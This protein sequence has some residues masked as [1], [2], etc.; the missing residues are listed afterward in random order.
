MELR[1]EKGDLTPLNLGQWK[2]CL[3]ESYGGYLVISEMPREEYKVLNENVKVFKVLAKE[4][5]TVKIEGVLPDGS[6]LLVQAGDNLYCV[7]N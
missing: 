6:R 4:G 1:G 7:I 5:K 3:D 2:N